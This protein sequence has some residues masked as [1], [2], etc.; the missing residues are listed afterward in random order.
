MFGRVEIPAGRGRRLVVPETA[1][2]RIG[3]LE[4]AT[5]VGS[6]GSRH[7]RLVTTGTATSGGV[8]VLSGLSAGEEV[9]LP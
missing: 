8:E 2:E 4:Y 3:Q 7:R 6:D 5:V 1:V 9:V